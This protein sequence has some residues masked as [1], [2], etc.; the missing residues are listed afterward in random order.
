MSAGAYR[1]HVV[2]RFLLLAI[3]LLSTTVQM[4]PDPTRASD[5]PR[6]YG[7]LRPAIAAAWLRTHHLPRASVMG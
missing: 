1:P 7:R 4:L 5:R 2:R 6:V 3:N